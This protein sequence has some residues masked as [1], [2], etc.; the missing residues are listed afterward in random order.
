MNSKFGDID[1]PVAG[2]GSFGCTRI[3]AGYDGYY[4][5]LWV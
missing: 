2:F 4:P 1:N 5:E 3:Y